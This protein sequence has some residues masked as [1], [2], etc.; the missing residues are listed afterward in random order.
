MTAKATARLSFDKPRAS[1]T[2]EEEA[3]TEQLCRDGVQP[4]RDQG[5]HCCALTKSG[6]PR[7]A[8]PT[9]RGQKPY[10]A[11]MDLVFLSMR[12]R[13]ACCAGR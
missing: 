2:P 11:T 10:L 4:F 12:A 7:K 6:R 1:R 8:V 3:T 9:G 13:A 5:E